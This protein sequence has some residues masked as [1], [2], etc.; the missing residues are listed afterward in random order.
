VVKHA[1]ASS[2][3]VCL[4]VAT[5]RAMLEIADDGVGFEP[6]LRG[7]G[8][9]GMQGMRERAQRL[10]GTLSIDSSPGAGT[11]LPVELPH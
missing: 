1:H 3:G 8:G 7:G 5:D 2:F 6:S 4:D 11:R 10:G 9:Y